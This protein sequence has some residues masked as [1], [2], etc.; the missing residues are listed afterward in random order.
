MSKDDLGDRMKMYEGR[1]AKRIFIPR[2]P[3]IARID[4]KNF[5]KLTR[6][7]VRPYDERMGFAMQATTIWLMRYTNACYGYTQSDEITLVWYHPEPASEP[8]FGHKI[9]KMCS[10][11]A[12]AATAR[13]TDIAGNLFDDLVMFDCR[14]WN[15]PTEEEAA[16]A[17]LW[18]TFDATKNSISMLAREYYSHK[19]LIGVTCDAMLCLLRNEHDID[20]ETYPRHF[21]YGT[22]YQR[23]TD[24]DGRN[25]YG[26]PDLIRFKDV[27]NRA[28]VVLRGAKP[29]YTEIE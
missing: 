12:S 20:W 3:I 23:F 15:V 14:V 28:D 25:K 11:L 9:Q 7:L 2:L 19:E 22:H 4:G 26:I 8:W 10:V 17:V 16:N 1:E 13:F 24:E 6:N 29:E 21:T 18:R 27:K 5:S